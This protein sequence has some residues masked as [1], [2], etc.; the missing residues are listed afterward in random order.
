[1]HTSQQDSQAMSIFPGHPFRRLPSA[2][3]LVGIPQTDL[4]SRSSLHLL[5]LCTNEIG[6]D[7][8]YVD[9][10]RRC[11]DEERGGQYIKARFYERVGNYVFGDKVP[12]E[13]PSYALRHHSEI[14]GERARGNC[15]GK[16]APSVPRAFQFA[17]KWDTP[18]L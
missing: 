1:M 10:T 8:H 3:E 6:L 17:R 12:A 14:A 18:A 11:K 2:C 5:C 16:R 15:R 4:I 9:S 13:R 7:A